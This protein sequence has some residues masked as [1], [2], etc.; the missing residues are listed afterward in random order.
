MPQ[1]NFI[2]TTSRQWLSM[3]QFPGTQ[4]LPLAEPV[5]EGAI[6]LL[7]MKAGTIIPVHTHPCDEYVYVLSGVV[8]TGG[9]TCSQGMFWT[10][11]AHIQQGC[12]KAITD[13][14]IITIRL[15]KMGVFKSVEAL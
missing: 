12:H 15:G 1:Q 3:D 6:H 13:V 2:Q 10:T 7:K 11:P 14:E 5:P 8:E 9:K 4:F